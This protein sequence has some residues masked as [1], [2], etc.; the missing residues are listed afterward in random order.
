M[1]THDVSY[2]TDKH[3]ELVHQSSNFVPAQVG[4]AHPTVTVVP[5]VQ[6]PYAATLPQPVQ[7]QVTTEVT[8]ISRA[9]A[10]VMKVNAVT[11]ALALFT[12]AALC[13]LQTFT[14][15]LWLLCASGEWVVCFVLVALLDWR[16]TPAALSWR[17]SEAYLALMRREQAARLQALYG[18]ETGRD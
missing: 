2:A 11:L 12:L 1:Q 17:Q 18:V 15:F 5:R 9:Q 16:E 14:L 4:E 7:H 6:D 13:L 8:P 3:M 10:L